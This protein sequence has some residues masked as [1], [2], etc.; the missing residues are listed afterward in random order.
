MGASW[1]SRGLARQCREAELTVCLHTAYLLSGSQK[2]QERGPWW[3]S[4]QAR[5]ALGPAL[6]YAVAA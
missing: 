5:W 2:A 6:V 4:S 1:S 3:P